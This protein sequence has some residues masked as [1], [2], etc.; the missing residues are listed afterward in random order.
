MPVV[1]ALLVPATQTRQPLQQLLRVPHLD[2]FGVQ[3]DCHHLANQPARHR[4]AVAL[5]VD[6][7][8]RVDPA[9]PLLERLQPP[10]RQRPQPAALFV[11]S[12]PTPGIELPELLAEELLVLHPARKIPTAAQ[13]QGLVQRRLETPMPLLNVAVLM[14]V[15]RLDLLAHQAIVLQQALVALGELLPLRQIVHRR[16]QPI[17]P[18]PRRH[19]AQLP[20]GVLQSFTQA[21]EA[22]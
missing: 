21:L 11:Q 3:P 17:G 14:G 7:T 5:D 19:A 16:A 13:H 10:R 22:L 18:M 1:H 2:H 8:A 6:Q 9:A 15:V 20:Q 12:L 4:V